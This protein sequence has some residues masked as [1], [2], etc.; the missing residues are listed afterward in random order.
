MCLICR[1]RLT[2]IGYSCR[3]SAAKVATCSSSA[4]VT[5]LRRST[6]EGPLACGAVPYAHFRRFGPPE[7]HFSL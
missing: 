2:L 6:E 5:F 4:W 1:E 7:L 3:G